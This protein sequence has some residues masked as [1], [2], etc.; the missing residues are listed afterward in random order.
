MSRRLVA[1]LAITA[2]LWG[3][4]AEQPEKTAADY[5]LL[6]GESIRF[7]DYAG[8]VVFINYWAEW[9]SP[10]REEIPDLN[11]LHSDFAGQVLVLG[12]NFDG[13]IGSELQQ[14]AEQLGIE[15]PLLLD[16]PREAFGV[17]ASGVLPET[18]VIDRRG[19]FQQVL[20]GPQSL[21]TL[22]RVVASMPEEMTG[23]E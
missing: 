11:A 15:F 14:Q 23:Y 17:A 5:Q 1:A 22:Q 10:C 4:S 13:V 19:Q 12:V 7:S 16:D 18:L 8:K 20:M 21:E 9:C 6:S 3:C 2:L